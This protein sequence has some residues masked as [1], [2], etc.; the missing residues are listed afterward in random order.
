M[1]Y[2]WEVYN[3]FLYEIEQLFEEDGCMGGPEKNLLESWTLFS[4]SEKEA[5]ILQDSPEILGEPV[6]WIDMESE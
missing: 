6:T 5:N 4:G 1:F 2:V 3:V